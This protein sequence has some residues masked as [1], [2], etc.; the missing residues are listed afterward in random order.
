METESNNKYLSV[1]RLRS[2]AKT[3]LNTIEQLAARG[4]RLKLMN[5]YLKGDLA[6]QLAPDLNRFMGRYPFIRQQSAMDCG[7]T[8]IAMI[9]QFHNRRCNLNLIREMAE[10]SRYGTSMLSLA[11]TAEKLGYLARG[12]RANYAGLMKLKLPLLCHWEN[13]HFIVLYEI[14]TGGAVIGDPAQELLR[15][16]RTKFEEAYSGVALE[17]T[18]ASNLD[19]R[20]KARSPFSV[21]IPLIQ[22][23]KTILRDIFI[24][25]FI[26]QV[27]QLF[28]P[29]C[30][31]IILDKVIIHQSFSMLNAILL[32]MVLLTLFG[33]AISYLRGFLIAFLS[34]KIDQSLFVE[35]YRHL[36]ALPLK[37][38]EQRTI[39]DVLARFGEN[40]KVRNFLA[41]SAVT[42]TLDLLV[43][44]VFLV[45]IFLYNK[46]FGL[47]TFV[48]LSCFT[49]VVFCYTPILR[50]LNRQAFDKN[51]ISSSFLVESIRAIEKV[52]ASAIEHHTRWHWEELFAD[53]LNVKFRELMARNVA[54][55]ASQLIRM[56]GQ[57]LLLWYGARLVID[58]QLTVGQLMSLN[59][60]VSMATQPLMRLIEVWNQFQ[61]VQISLE[62]LGDV[63]EA[64]P[65]EAE[66]SKKVLKKRTDG[67]IKF[68]S[69]TF[70]YSRIAPSKALVDVTF[71]AQPG[72][73]IGIV[74]RSGCGKSTLLKLILGLYM[75]TEGRVLIDNQDIA[76]LSLRDL[77]NQIG[78]VSQNEYFFKGT[79]RE[80][81]SL[82]D[83]D[84]KTESLVAAAR[85]ANIEDFINAQPHGIETNVNEGAFDLSGGQRQ[86]LAIARSL[87]HD[88]K[89]LLFDEA[90]SNLDSESEEHIQNSIT[91]LRQ[92]RTMLVVAHRLST[93]R[94]ADLILVMDSGQI[95]EQ[96]THKALMSQR[97]LYYSFVK[98]Q[99]TD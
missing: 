83:Q 80:N 39:G 21:L 63:F 97:G 86:R 61:E 56:G 74:G 11:E 66:P 68:E 3:V 78:V 73:V 84:A 58:E 65:E 62:R 10:T 49:A 38:F 20:F 85:A 26:Y 67:H 12:V 53:S 89:I 2:G 47:W 99:S 8:C 22:P 33:T 1:E 18:P 14:N 42:V 57:V 35:F 52:K 55:A 54:S 41:S 34:I 28:I 91:K 87:V 71:E 44:V 15:I 95:A 27:L 37:F 75:P 60:M 92:G 76:H 94:D 77:R 40:E 46:M 51:V 6:K 72:Q 19:E 17:L 50:K 79:I 16:D 25:T 24:A 23:H 7:P 96:G 43:A 98:R 29:L 36:L 4:G 32:G 30:T 64:E 93:V 48:Y 88:P 69:V 81:L 13:N 90:T 9:S 31:Q 59:M 82:Y 45:C 5:G 70:T